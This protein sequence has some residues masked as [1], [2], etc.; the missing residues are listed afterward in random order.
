[1]AIP[2]VKQSGR[3]WD[4][5]ADGEAASN[6]SGT[7][8]VTHEI[9]VEF[10]LVHKP[11]NDVAVAPRLTPL[12]THVPTLPAPMLPVPMSSPPR[13]RAARPKLPCRLES[14]T[15][16]SRSVLSSDASWLAAS[17]R[18]LTESAPDVAE[19]EDASIEVAEASLD[20]DDVEAIDDS[21]LAPLRACFERG[22]YFGVLRAGE[23]LL[24]RRPDLTAALSYVAAARESLLRRY[25]A[26]LGGPRQIPRLL[27]HA[28]EI[29]SLSLDHREAFLLSLI[30]GVSAVDE[31]V[32]MSGLPE[33]DAL[34]LLSHL[35]A[36]GLV[37]CEQLVSSPGATSGER[38]AVKHRGPAKQ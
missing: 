34:R 23:A 22:E 12:P 15:T 26:E 31:I 14:W 19:L 17:V 20:P 32:D 4:D 13:A 24:E 10:G 27:V 33:L 16:E 38:L 2:D 35:S 37:V 7:R 28:P 1:M 3:T 36:R 18:A 30:D 29:T 21:D 11:C 5:A 25:L 9:D 8:R 6:E